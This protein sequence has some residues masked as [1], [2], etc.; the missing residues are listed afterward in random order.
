MIL[1]KCYQADAR[2]PL[3]AYPN[4]AGNDL[5]AN[6][7]TFTSER[8]SMVSVDLKLAIPKGFF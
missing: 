2:T 4:S 7:K 8:E 3:K 1:F 5:Y 6:E